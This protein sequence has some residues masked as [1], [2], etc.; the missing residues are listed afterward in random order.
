MESLM[1]SL[2]GKGQEQVF[3]TMKALVEDAGR[4]NDM[5]IELKELSLKFEKL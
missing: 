5:D 3:D 2:L 1:Q 4:V